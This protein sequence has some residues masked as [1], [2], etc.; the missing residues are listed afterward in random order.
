MIN[1]LLLLV[2]AQ[3][4]NTAPKAVLTLPTKPVVAGKPFD[5]T[6]VLT[7]ADGLHGYQNPPADPD[8]IPVDVKLKSGSVKLLSVDYPKG[9]SYGTPPVKVYSGATTIHLKFKAGTKSGPLVLSVNYQQCNDASC[10]PPDS[11]SVT[12]KL[13]VS[14]K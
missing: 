14:S 9:V 6:L 7:F 12:G 10:F 5:A 2:A 3:P 13:S 1:S 8:E 4:V 11:V